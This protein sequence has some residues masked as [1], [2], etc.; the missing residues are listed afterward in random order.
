M[1]SQNDNNSESGHIWACARWGGLLG[2]LPTVLIGVFAWAR[3]YSPEKILP[4]F[5][6]LIL[7]LHSGEFFYRVL[8]KILP[9]LRGFEHNNS[10]L[11]VAMVVAMSAM[12][13]TVVGALLGAAYAETKRRIHS[14]PGSDRHA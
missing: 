5:G 7:M 4:G 12:I 9:Y 13:N 10:R 11:W 6:W 2:L 3:F 8:L 1:K 14:L